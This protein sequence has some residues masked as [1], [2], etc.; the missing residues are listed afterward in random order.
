MEN[1]TH[2]DLYKKYLQNTYGP[3]VFPLLRTIMVLTTFFI[4][5][6]LVSLNMFIV[7]SGEEEKKLSES[8]E[9]CEVKKMELP[10]RPIIIF[11]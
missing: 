10:K 9:I 5:L 11:E 6:I 8:T 1:Y 2:D 7:A 3:N 4:I